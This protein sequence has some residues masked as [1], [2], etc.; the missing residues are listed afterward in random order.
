MAVMGLQLQLTQDPVGCWQSQLHPEGRTLSF[1]AR[2]LACGSK[3]TYT[4]CRRLVVN[5]LA[6]CTCTAA[7]HQRLH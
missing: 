6:L 3:L 4:S 7:C 1:R 5:V 2:K